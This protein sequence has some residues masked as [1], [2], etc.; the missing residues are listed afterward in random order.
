[1]QSLKNLLIMCTKHLAC[2]I[3]YLAIGLSTSQLVAQ[4][5]VGVGTANPVEKLHVVGNLQL[6]SS[7]LGHKIILKDTLGDIRFILDPDNGSMQMLSQDTVWS[8]NTTNS[9]HQEIRFTGDGGYVVR[10]LSRDSAFT[11]YAE[12]YV[13]NPIPGQPPYLWYQECRN[14]STVDS[15]PIVPGKGYRIVQRRTTYSPLGCVIQEEEQRLR[16]D[17]NDTDEDEYYWV[18]TVNDCG[19]DSVKKQTVESNARSSK[20]FSP[21]TEYFWGANGQGVIGGLDTVCWITIPSE[22]ELQLKGVNTFNF[23]Q[24]GPFQFHFSDSTFNDTLHLQIDPAAHLWTFSHLLCIPAIKTDSVKTKKLQLFNGEDSIAFEI[25]APDTSAPGIVPLTVWDVLKIGAKKVEQ[26]N[27]ECGDSLKLIEGW[28]DDCGTPQYTF[29]WHAPNDSAKMSVSPVPTPEF[30]FWG[31][32]VVRP[33]TSGGLTIPPEIRMESDSTCGSGID[34]RIQAEDC[35]TAKIE[36]VKGPDTNAI[37]LS[38]SEVIFTSPLQ[39]DTLITPPQLSFTIRTA[40][41]TLPQM[42]L[43]W[44]DVPGAV[45]YQFKGTSNTSKIRY[46]PDQ[47]TVRYF[48]FNEHEIQ[49]DLPLLIQLFT[50]SSGDTMSFHVDHTNQRFEYLQPIR[51]PSIHVD[52]LRSVNSNYCIV[53]GDLMANKVKT[54]SL[55][56]STGSALVINSGIKTDSLIPST[57]SALVVVGGVRVDSLYPSTGSALVVNGNVKADSLYPSTG[58]ELVVGSDL[59]V[60]GNFNCPAV[61][62]DTILSDSLNANVVCTN[63]AKMPDG[64]GGQARYTPL[65]IEVTGFGPPIG[66]SW[67]IFSQ[68]VNVN[69]T[70]TTNDILGDDVVFDETIVDTLIAN[71]VAKAAGSFKIDHPLDPYNKYLYHSFVESPDMMNVYNGNITTDATGHA[72]VVLPDYFEALNKDFRYQLTVIGSFA[73]AIVADEIADNKFV[74]ATDKPN[75]KVSWQVTGIRNDKYA[76]ENRIEVEVK[77]SAAEQGRLLYTD[78]LPADHNGR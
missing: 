30:G 26:V 32:V 73:Q 67:D 13:K 36:V 1:M 65:G 57:G 45:S 43:D 51:T 78:K 31:N 11:W 15:L 48:G 22:K 60:I 6:D 4:G 52:T 61:N 47:K 5:N 37:R 74:V 18:T 7:L 27:P 35:S 33:A 23:G 56:P 19:D 50:T 77:K 53:D 70:L 44:A 8:L 72:T 62:S 75:V 9:P 34:L 38:S 21:D 76:Q 14:G 42:T 68:M 20:F 40:T 49:G 24:E 25:C 71:F 2:T 10:Y 66:F 46:H 55:L 3:L 41:P 17:P 58:S 54:D 63:E 64:F 69:G 59:G 28:D 16:P 12:T 29:E 39:F